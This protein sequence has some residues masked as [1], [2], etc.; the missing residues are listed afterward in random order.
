M[1]ENGKYIYYQYYLNKA[2]YSYLDYV[3]T[4]VYYKL[5]YDEDSHDYIYE[6]RYYKSCKDEIESQLNNGYRY[7]DTSK[8]DSDTDTYN[9]FFYLYSNPQPDDEE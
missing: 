8:Y 9:Y 7:G 4:T 5:G 1:Q 3:D 6:N 2:Q